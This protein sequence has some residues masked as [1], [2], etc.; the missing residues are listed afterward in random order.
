MPWRSKGREVQKKSGGK[1]IHHAWAKSAA[2][3]KR[4]VKLLYSKEKK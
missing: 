3:A 4:M 1:W 2:S